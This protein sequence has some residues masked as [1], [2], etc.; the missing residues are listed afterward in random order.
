M[1][2]KA[3]QFNPSTP[4][5]STPTHPQLSVIAPEAVDSTS[6]AAAQQNLIRGKMNPFESHFIS[7]GINMTPA[8]AQACGSDEV[9]NYLSQL[10]S[11]V[12]RDVAP[13]ELLPPLQAHGIFCWPIHLPIPGFIFPSAKQTP[14]TT[15][16]PQRSNCTAMAPT[17]DQQA[18][19]HC[20]TWGQLRDC[21]I[22]D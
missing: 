20:S 1:V 3:N 17:S 7:G 18:D 12:D 14:L 6:R 8:I 4:P 9:G 2:L 22:V 19:P 5:S 11:L 21:A 13:P 16:G 10:A 15:P